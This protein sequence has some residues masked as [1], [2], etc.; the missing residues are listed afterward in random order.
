LSG[1]GASVTGP[2]SKCGK[3]K[4]IKVQ[5]KKEEDGEKRGRGGGTNY[6]WRK[7]KKLGWDVIKK[8]SQGGTQQKK[9]RQPDKVARYW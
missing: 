7:I 8:N 9:T 3:R 2:T 6:M 5:G 1:G 4:K